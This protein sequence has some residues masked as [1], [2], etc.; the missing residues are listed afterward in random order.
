MT[1]REGE[2][3]S[4]RRLLALFATLLFTLFGAGTGTLTFLSGDGDGDGDGE[5]AGGLDLSVDYSV[6]P[7][8][9]TTP[10]D[11]GTEGDGSDSAADPDGTDGSPGTEA[12]FVTPPGDSSSDDGDDSPSDDDSR[13]SE[14]RR[15]DPAAD[16]LVASSV[17]PVSVPELMPGDGGDVDLS[18]SL[19]GSPARLWVRA[20]VTDTTERAVVEPERSAGDTD[21][22]GELHEHVRVRLWCDLDDD[23]TID[24]GEPVAYDGTLAELDAADDWIALTDSCVSTGDHTVRFRWDVP[25]DVPNTVQADGATFSLRVGAEASA[26]Q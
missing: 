10:T 4:R 6:N 22:S 1:E 5:G 24:S 3:S 14:R 2:D 11:G 16:D 9:S 18:L 20:D 17:P 21:Q 15:T 23:G 8:P 7:D 13:S 25:T 12:P 19:S 26:C